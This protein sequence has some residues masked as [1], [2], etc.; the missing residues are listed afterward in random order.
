MSFKNII[1]KASSEIKTLL[2]NAYS[3]GFQDGREKGIEEGRAT[4]AI[5]ELQGRDRFLASI[6]ESRRDII[7]SKTVER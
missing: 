2:E 7:P 5:L 6:K 3:M 1:D 4:Q